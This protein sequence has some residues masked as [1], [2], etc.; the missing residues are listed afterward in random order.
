MDL[1]V[2]KINNIKARIELRNK[3]LAELQRSLKSRLNVRRYGNFIVI[4]K[5]LTYV[6]WPDSGTVNIIGLT[7]FQDVSSAVLEMCQEFKIK[8]S[9]FRSQ[10]IIDNVCANG[11]FGKLIELSK[12]EKKLY[13]NKSFKVNLNRDYRPGA[14]CRTFAGIGTIIVFSTGA[15]IIVGAKCL[16]HVETMFQNMSAIIATL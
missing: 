4:K 13:G 15:Y 1:S 3:D 14:V 16:E 12:L 5:K 8:E 11:S 9:R 6:V 7:R 2:P 10:L